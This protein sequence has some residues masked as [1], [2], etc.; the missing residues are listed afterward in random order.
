MNREGKS[1]RLGI[2]ALSGMVFVVLTGCSSTVPIKINVSTAEELPASIAIDYLNKISD[3]QKERSLPMHKKYA[4]NFNEKEVFIPA[5]SEKYAETKLSIEAD[6][7]AGRVLVRVKLSMI[8]GCL[9]TD[10]RYQGENPTDE[11]M[12]I[13][14]KIA[15]AAKS[16]GIH[17]E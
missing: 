4:C 5:A 8:Y 16:L 2:K 17:L 6:S 10:M 15:T 7:F 9:I 12:K 13:L 3:L 14:A 1:R 11:Q